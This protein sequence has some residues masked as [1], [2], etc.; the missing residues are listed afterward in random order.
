MVNIDNQDYAV[1][2]LRGLWRSS[3]VDLGMIVHII[4]SFDNDLGDEI[5]V[6]DNQNF[7]VTS[8]NVIINGT[9]V[10]ASNDC[11][12]RAFLG[13]KFQ[14]PS[15]KPTSSSAFVGIYFHEIFQHCLMTKDFS[16]ESV[17]SFLN[18]LIETQIESIYGLRSLG[19]SESSLKA[20]LLEFKRELAKFPRE[21]LHQVLTRFTTTTIEVLTIS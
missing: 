4:G 1:C 13:E 16:D 3:R 19:I 9:T 7:F 5:I 18:E 17:L 8:P 20:E 15:I 12:R 21:H 6:D 10:S 2:R 14:G 11:E